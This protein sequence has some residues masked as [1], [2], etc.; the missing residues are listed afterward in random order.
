MPHH[1]FLSSPLVIALTLGIAGCGAP[2]ATN[3]TTV[4]TNSNSNTHANFNMN[5]NASSSSSS[6]VESREPDAYQA[7]VTL[8]VQALGNQTLNLP[9]I[10]ALVSKKGTD[11]RMDFTV[12]TQGHIVY[13]DK[14]GNTH[15]LLLPDKKQYA[16]LTPEAMGFEIR[17]MLTPGELVQQAK[18]L[19]GVERIGD[20]T[21][22]GRSVV[23]YKYAAQANTG[24]QAGDVA[25][26][27]F[28]YVDKETGL[29][30]HS[31]TVSQSKTGGN[32]QGY[33]GLR[34]ITEIND[35]KTDVSDDLFTKP[36]DY[37]QIDPAQVKATVD[38]VFKIITTAL[39][40]VMNSQAAPAANTAPAMNSNSH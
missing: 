20:D 16:E 9:S 14:G 25:T 38:M 24:T 10:S 15:L 37:Q 13:L 35:I 27:S 26:D 32:V 33:N 12:P 2:P 34:V 7:T 8:K 28:L 23:K 39:T 11:S 19:Q 29:P 30:L 21:Y 4:N 17:K 1:K 40:Q 5:S 6:M 3:V 31:E 18:N 36:A 22:N